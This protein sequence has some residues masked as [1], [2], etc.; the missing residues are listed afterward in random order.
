MHRSLHSLRWVCLLLATLAG[1]SLRSAADSI[2][3]VVIVLDASGSMRTPFDGNRDRMSAAKAALKQV[4]AK[5]PKETHLGLLVFS[6]ANLTNDWAFPLGP[7]DDAVLNAAI[8]SIVASRGTPLGAYIKRGADRLLEERARQFGYGTFRLLIVTDGEAQDQELVE[9]YTPEVIARGLTVDVIGVAM[10]T[11]H[12]LATRVHSYR[13]ANDPAALQKALAAVFAEVSTS[14]T[15]ATRAGDFA[16]IA[17]LPAPA[18]VAMLQ[19]ISKAEN[20]P[21]G[22]TRRPTPR[23]TANP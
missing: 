23:K 12:T 20:G 6:A 21:V 7:R 5:V 19:A 9:K 17:P 10:N 16:L 1:G 3:N 13:G 22:E 15:D 8:D 2:D 11:R 4:I 18:A 14:A